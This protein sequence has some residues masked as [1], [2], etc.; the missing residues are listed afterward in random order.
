MSTANR[1][2]A[3]EML[4][5]CLPSCLF[6]FAISEDAPR[7]CYNNTFHLEIRTSSDVSPKHF[8]F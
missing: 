5:L 8:H 2:D 4:R 7:F 1:Q 3:S 6:V